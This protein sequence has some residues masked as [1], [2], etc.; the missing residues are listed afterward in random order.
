MWHG[1]SAPLL[2]LVLVCRAVPLLAQPGAPE[3][4]PEVPAPPDLPPEAAEAPPQEPGGLS[5]QPPAEI[6]LQPSCA[7]WAAR[8]ECAANAAYML[9]HCPQSC[10]PHHHSVPHEPAECSAE[11]LE[12]GSCAAP[13]PTQ[14]AEWQPH[15]MELPPEPGLP[16]DEAAEN[17]TAPPAPDEAEEV[18]APEDVDGDLA[19]GMTTTQ[20]EDLRAMSEDGAGDVHGMLDGT[21]LQAADPEPEAPPG[22]E[23]F[24]D[25]SWSRDAAGAPGSVE[26][27]DMDAG[28]LQEPPQH[29]K[30][31][32]GGAPQVPEAEQADLLDRVGLPGA[33]TQMPT[34]PP[35][36]PSTTTAGSVSAVFTADTDWKGAVV[37][38]YSVARTLAQWVSAMAV[39]AAGVAAKLLYADP[40]LNFVVIIF[41]MFMAAL[42]FFRTLPASGV[43]VAVQAPA[44]AARPAPRVAAP[45]PPQATAESAKILA[46]LQQQVEDLQRLQQQTAAELRRSVAENAHSLAQLSADLQEFRQQRRTIDD[47]L[48]LSAKEV[49]EWVSGGNVGC[50]AAP[51]TAEVGAPAE[52]MVP[53]AYVPQPE[54]SAPAQEPTLAQ[55]SG[56]VQASAL[57][58]SLAPV[59]VPA[60]APV[61]VPAS[62]QAPV[63]ARAPVASPPGASPGAPVPPDSGTLGSALR[64]AEGEPPAPAQPPV[65]AQPSV[66]V[67]PPAPTQ[68]PAPLHAPA[69]EAPEPAGPAAPPQAPVPGPV[70]PPWAAAAPGGPAAPRDAAGP[71]PWPA[72]VVPGGP[73]PPAGRPGSGRPQQQPIQAAASPFG[74][75]RPQPKEI[76]AP[77]GPF[78]PR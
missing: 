19:L 6:D 10:M 68:P 56:P 66:P 54:A 58:Q 11:A 21:S 27:M 31:V 34:A 45:Q 13:A 30:V 1:P 16:F 23:G 49:L 47:E 9:R 29:I 15:T 38:I 75:L 64:P 57:V 2:C 22:D 50:P 61:P 72:S 77:T 14:E 69:R 53:E 36:A 42:I 60:P 25:D 48:L 46:A 44:A 18:V 76:V 8:G 73:R 40:P 33:G 63:S 52:T 71:Q 62:A 7:A 37:A 3:G 17:A 43:A 35:P 67:Q 55:A 12:E 59:E 70:R 39:E 4:A 24:R 28:I 41:A 74:A 26:E 5:E 20:Q 32:P 65:P 51:V 78:G